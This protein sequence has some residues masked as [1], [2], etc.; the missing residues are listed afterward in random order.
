MKG[1]VKYLQRMHL[2]HIATGQRAAT[3]AFLLGIGLFA[4]GHFASRAVAEPPSDYAPDPLP[5]GGDSLTSI[6]VAVRMLECIDCEGVVYFWS[7]RMPLSRLGISEVAEATQKL[8][9]HLTLVASEEIEE[10]SGGRWSEL[11]PLERILEAGDLSHA[12]ALVVHKNGALSGKAILGHKTAEAYRSLIA[13]RLSPSFET[14]STEASWR[15]AEQTSAPLNMTD[16]SALGIPGAYFRWVPGWNALAYESGRRVYLLDLEDGRSRVAPGHIDFIPTPDGRFFVTP[17]LNEAGLAFYEAAEVFE[18]AH[19]EQS[20]A[21]R[22][23]FTDGSMRDQYPSVGILEDGEDGTRYRVLTSWFQGIVYRDY[24][25]TVDEQTGL[26]SVHPLGQPVVPCRGLSLSIPILSQTG[27]EV[28][29]RD[30]ATGT[31]KVFRI[32]GGGGCE[33]VIDLGVQTSKVAWHQ[34]GDRLA[35]RV[36]RLAS[37][38]RS[39]DDGNQ[40]IF[41]YDRESRTLSAVPGSEGASSLAFPDFVGDESIV[42]MLPGQTRGEASRFRVINGVN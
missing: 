26:T 23:V 27:H 7:S 42:F 5:E 31:T 16:Y 34:T 10:Y 3:L 24:D 14:T 8:G 28:A 30:E 11:R 41:V 9:I 21:V 1:S 38:R 33:E 36:P 19:N 39:A 2:L 20:A 15:I 6:E 40:G 35:F 22:P 4:S 13:E 18:A 12:P 29:A 17:T 32:I 37:V 25:V